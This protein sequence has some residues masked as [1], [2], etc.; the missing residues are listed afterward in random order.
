MLSLE[1]FAGAGG[2][3]LATA[4]AG[5]HHAAVLEWN[6]NACATL[7]YNQRAGLPQLAGA[8]IV[9]GDVS[10]YDFKKHAGTVE[11]VSGGPPCQP[12]SIGGSHGGMD[13]DRNMFPQAVRAVREIRPKAFIFENVKGL[14][15]ES[16]ASYYEYIIHQLTYPEIVRRGDE[17]WPDHHARLEKA[18]TSGTKST[19]KY[20]VIRQL[21]L[22]LLL[23]FTMRPYWSGI[24]TLPRRSATSRRQRATDDATA[25]S[26]TA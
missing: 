20:Q 26:R 9:E 18:V 6:P 3:A 11:L 24:R 5:F 25:N 15:R 4:N 10:H 23:A 1:L 19:L 22:R 2:L 13:D 17:E 16:F 7:R 8:V 21:F 14:L 12:F